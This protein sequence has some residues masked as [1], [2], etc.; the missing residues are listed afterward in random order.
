MGRRRMVRSIESHARSDGRAAEVRP[1]RG[2][3]AEIMQQALGNRMTAT[4]TQSAAAWGT[5]GPGAPLPHLPTLQRAFGRHDLSR[6]RAHTDG[7]ARVSA[8]AIGAEAFAIGE[9]VGFSGPP[10]LRVAAHEAAH[11]VQQQ[12]GARP[13]G[14]VGVA[15]D[16]HERHADAVADLVVSGRSAEALLDRVAPR[17]GRA[18]AP[19]SPSV[20][21]ILSIRGNPLTA[22]AITGHMPEIRQGFVRANPLVDISAVDWN[23]VRDQLLR[24]AN[25]VPEYRFNLT[26]DAILEIIQTGNADGI[27]AH[28][29]VPPAPAPAPAPAPEPEVEAYEQP[30]Y[31]Q[32]EKK[33]KQGKAS[34]EASGP[35]LTYRHDPHGQA[36]HFSGRLKQGAQWSLTFSSADALMLAD[37]KANLDT[38]LKHSPEGAVTL[39]YLT[40]DNGTSVGAVDRSD[41]TTSYYT[42]QIDVDRKKNEIVYHGYPVENSA[43]LGL[44]KTVKNK[45]LPCV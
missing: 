40:K 39:F 43:T 20:Q 17:P 5:R 25:A 19:A 26:S 9:Q 2:S 34:A 41:N 27:L 3:A 45:D 8:A 29:Y 11:V 37:V 14:G 22:V 44:G 21:R 42:I 1:P 12:G 23:H 16:E 15:G 36:K 13:A 18:A 28:P 35:V 32:Y 7:A 10:S 31:S 33:K 4:W 38:L 6:V 30:D 24:V